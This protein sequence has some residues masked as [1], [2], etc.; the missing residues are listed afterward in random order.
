MGRDRSLEWTLARVTRQRSPTLLVE[1]ILGYLPWGER[2]RIAVVDV[3]EERLPR[4]EGLL[5]FLQCTQHVCLP[6]DIS[7]HRTH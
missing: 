1:I 7:L 4:G 5:W 2:G 3:H 6:S